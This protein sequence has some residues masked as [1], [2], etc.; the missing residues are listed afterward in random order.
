[1]ISA[2][3]QS[4]DAVVGFLRQYGVTSSTVKSH[5]GYVVAT[6]SA[7]VGSQM[8]ATQLHSLRHLET[9][10]TVRFHSLEGLSIPEELV[11][12]VVYISGIST[13]VPRVLKPRATI[14]PGAGSGAVTVTD[15]KNLYSIPQTYNITNGDKASQAVAEF[16]YQ[17]FDPADV[18]LFFEKYSTN[19]IGRAV[20]K[21]NGTN[22]PTMPKAESSLDVEYIMSMG[23]NGS[24]AFY[25]VDDGVFLTSLIDFFCGFK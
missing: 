10:Q 20:Y 19:N 17:W 8:F 9:N 22:R 7:L 15:L 1:M 11:S 14:H 23:S 12:V 6:V 25:Y 2:T 24:T 18:E 5:G 4:I 21:I 3:D 13:Q 16:Q